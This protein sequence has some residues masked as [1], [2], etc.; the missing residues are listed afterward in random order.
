MNTVP[1]YINTRG[2]AYCQYCLEGYA[3]PADYRLEER[4]PGACH[5]CAGEFTPEERNYY[6]ADG[7]ALAPA[8]Q[9][10]AHRLMNMHREEAARWLARA[11]EH[12]ALMPAYLRWREQALRNMAYWAAIVADEV[13]APRRPFPEIK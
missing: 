4:A 8:G 12:T 2:E 7:F 5:N 3:T 13:G 6:L 10:T 1:M 11:A 9:S